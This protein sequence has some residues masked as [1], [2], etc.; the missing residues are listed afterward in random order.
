M[1]VKNMIVATLPAN[2]LDRAKKFYTESFG[3]TV[4][5]QDP[6]AGLLLDCKGT[7]LHLY[8]WSPVKLGPAMITFQVDDLKSTVQDLRRRGYKFLDYDI[9]NASLKT[10]DG[11]ATMGDRMGAWLKDTEGN[12]I[13]L[14]QWLRGTVSERIKESVEAGKEAVA[15]R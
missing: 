7:E 3:C 15:P 5:S 2:D 1:A 8:Q 10:V 6:K 14:T 12:I 13:M 9:A 4:K 11:I